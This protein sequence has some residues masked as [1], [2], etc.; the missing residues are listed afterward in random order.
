MRLNNTD[1]VPLKLYRF[2]N[3]KILCVNYYDAMRKVVIGYFTTRS[4]LVIQAFHWRKSISN[5]FFRKLLPVTTDR[6]LC[7]KPCTCK[8]S[9]SMLFFYILITLAKVHLSETKSQ[10]SVL[11]TIGLLIRYLRMMHYLSGLY[12]VGSFQYSG[13][14]CSARIGMVTLQ[15]FFSF[16]PQTSMS[17]FGSRAVLYHRK[18]FLSITFTNQC[19]K[20]GMKYMSI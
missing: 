8:Y 20:Y 5:G 10:V 15:P 18:V 12:F 2:T 11:R 3:K 19:T 4:N 1:L 13:I 16:I 14:K 6:L 17:S 9:S 7:L